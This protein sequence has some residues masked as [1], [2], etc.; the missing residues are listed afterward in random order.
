[1]N[2]HM[3]QDDEASAELRHLAAVPRQIISPANNSPIIGIF[4]DS[5]LGLYRF[6]RENIQFD[7]RQAMNLLMTHTNVNKSL[8]GN[9]K[10]LISNFELFSQILPPLSTKFNNG[11][12]DGDKDDKKTSNNVIEILNGKMLR[13]QLDKGVKKLI[14]SIFNDFGFNSSADFIDHLQGI[15]TEYMK[16]SAFSVGISDL[17]AD[18][19]TNDKITQ[20]ITKKKQQ[21]KDIIDQ[22]QI[23]VFE[24]NS[25]KSNE[26][27]FETQVN[28]ILNKAREEAGK[29][30]RNS[31]DKN[32]RFVVMVNAGS[33]GS[34][35][36]IAQMISCLGQQNVDG[37]RIGYGFEDRTLPHYNKFDD[38]PEARGFVE[39]SFIQGLSP[40]ELFF[41]AMGGRV[42][43][44]DTAVKSVTWETPIV[45]IENGEP[46]YSEIGRWID[47][48]LEN[49]KE[50]VRHFEERQMEYLNVNNN[51][52]IPTTDENGII[53]WGEITAVTRHDPGDELY[54]IK[55]Q[56]G[57]EVIVTESK[58]LLIW[59][60]DTK[61]FVETLTPDIIVGD[62]VPVTMDLCDS[63]TILNEINMEKYFPK[64]KYI[65]GNDLIIGLK[66]MNE[67][68]E[69]KHKIEN[70]WWDKN[71]NNIFTLPYNKKSS[72]QRFAVRSNITAI[73]EDYIY[74][75]HSK[76]E[77][78]G[79][80][81]KFELNY[82]NGV[83]IGL[84][85]AEGN[86]HSGSLTITNNNENIQL[87]VK[88]WFNKNNI[89]YSIV[90]KINNIGGKTYSIRGYSSMMCNFIDNF[91]GS[92]AS[93]KFIP[94]E[95]FISNKDFVKGLL[96]GYFSGD[97]HISRNSIEASSASKRLIEG[98][99]MLC[100]R[101]GIFC[102]VFM[103]Q[104]KKNNLNTQ[105]IKPSYR[106]SIRSQWGKLFSENILLID[107]FKQDKLNNIKWNLKH[108]N[109][110]VYN[111]VVLDKIIS[112]EIVDVKK[113][114]KV[115][116]LTIPS[117]LNFGL[118][119]GLQVRDTSETGYIQRRLIKGMEDLKV[120][121]DMTVRNNMGKIVQFEYGDDSMETTKVESQTLP[122]V[123][124]TVEDI[125]SHYTI[126]D[127]VTIEND[128]NTMTFTQDALK[129]MTSQKIDLKQKTMNYIEN[130][131][132]TRKELVENVF[133]MEHNKN[134]NCPVHF[135]RIINNV[136]HQ[137][138]IKSNSLVDVT[139]LECFNIIEECKET[140]QKI[141]SVK[142]NKLFEALFNYYMIPKE[143][144]YI[145]RY[146]RASLNYLTQVIITNYK[147]SIIAPGEMV[148]MIAAQSIGEPT[149]QLTL[150]S[151]TYETEIP[152]RDSR[153][154]MYNVQIGDFVNK[155]INECIGKK[156]YYA[157]KD[158][159]Y[160][161]L[162]KES[163]YYEI[164][165]PSEDGEMLWCRIE[166]VTKHPVVNEDG[167]NTML[168]ITTENEREVIVTKAKSLLKVID[169]KLLESP[170]S[171]AKIGDY[172][173]INT[174]KYQHT[175][176]Y[177]LDLKTVLSPKE[178]L[179]MS[180][181][182][183]AIR[184]KDEGHWWKK[185]NNVD[186]VLP[187]S[188][189]DAFLDMVERNILHT[190]K[191]NG[192][193]N[194]VH[195]E[196]G[197]VYMKHN[198][199]TASQ[200]PEL[201]QLDYDFGYLL[202]AY[203]AEGCVTK[204]QISIANINN[205]YLEPIKRFC[206]KFNITYKVYKTE[207]K[208]QERWT[209]QD[210]RI[211]SKLLT[212]LLVKLCNKISHTKTLSNTIVYSNDECK[213]GFL[214][215]YIGG[216]G[217]ISKKEKCII[218]FSTSK[219]L[220]EKVQCMLN[221]F[222][223]Y[224]FIRKIK[225]QT[226]NNRGTTDFQQAYRLYVSNNQC[227]KLSS[228]LDIKIDYKKE[229]CM[230]KSCQEMKL[231]IN[232]FNDAYI[233][234]FNSEKQEYEMLKRSDVNDAYK[235]IVFEKIKSIE[236]VS[237]TTDYAYD[238]T[239][240]TTRNFVTVNGLNLRDTFHSAGISSK[241]NVTRGV[242]R[243]QEILSLSKE[244]KNP[245]LSIYLKPEDQHNKLKAQQLM[246]VLEHTQ[247]R[248]VVESV[249]ICYD[250]DN[251]NTLIDEDKELISQYKMFE[252][253]T[254]ECAQI[255]PLDTQRS[256]WIIR[257]VL[258]KEA[259]LDKNITMDDVHFAL[260][261][262]YKDEIECIFSDF[263]SDK[264]VFR[265]RLM[266]LLK[267]KSIAGASKGLDQSDD[268]YMLKNVQESMLDNIILKGAKN[269]TKVILRK[270]QDNVVKEGLDYVKQ[271]AWVLDTIGTNLLDMLSFDEIDNTRT[272][273][274]DIIEVHNV[275]G[276]EATRQCIYNEIA[277]VLEFD[278]TYINYHHMAL[279]CDRM[280]YSKNLISIFRHG[281][282]NDN[283]GPIA[284]AT[285]EETPEMFLR[286]ARHAEFDNMRGV[287]ANI[288]C[289]QEGN[290]GT[291]SFQVVVDLMKMTALGN[292]TLQQVQN[293]DDMFD[294]IE[295][296]DD[297]CAI[298]NIQTIS[299]VNVIKSVNVGDDNDYEPDF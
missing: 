181:V 111:N 212:E 271:E 161:E 146:N 98:I 193:N 152:V 16:T 60:K 168:K 65:H 267:K 17:I 251:L 200:L 140:I 27:E 295:N 253:M 133:K 71:N 197:N 107:N 66:K 119:N 157:S 238:L 118:A 110:D 137:M 178:Y 54:K 281:I 74:P 173:P 290:F 174:M 53:T 99:S 239:V 167:T 83:F 277:D 103:T 236:E 36:N 136:K 265:V 120:E 4:Q 297:P 121:Y 250:P 191:K 204:T 166:A 139:P 78:V 130:M 45:F 286:A 144:L 180:E 274:N 69:G 3:P 22:L 187:Y 141:H 156:E 249:S 293:I 237:N 105:N 260:N 46:K 150:N 201:M 208:I 63:S 89:T 194:S 231:N 148:G 183:K 221:T 199:R 192:T 261:A 288:M 266:D 216:D 282:N 80:H 12:F 292:K 217:Y 214:D 10:K 9:Q 245:S 43:L 131:I 188:R 284:K 85:L 73:K 223:I 81:N 15:V 50:K 159:T 202:G 40:Q 51:I 143:L 207:N 39:N 164:L 126:P 61:K 232:K 128:L 276:I 262:G 280:C 145:H 18:E 129:R 7:S 59:N 102:K 287:S 135:Q 163:Q 14:H 147:K 64:N 19:E 294:G 44:I 186:F 142:V 41:H 32:N 222:E 115:Y 132:D 169:G 263:N 108:K 125:Y 48:Q 224:S 38:G 299:N 31:L 211:Y 11:I 171:D 20:A 272:F 278:G 258:D 109:F 8:F 30:G 87:F 235:N 269:I 127:D 56:G 151:V 6:T 230:K 195:Y 29:I 33:K 196:Y 34:D 165:A 248:D 26:E 21:V 76:R 154:Y 198:S 116:D 256:K 35:I 124:M 289:G 240:E 24:N 185:H 94:N 104:L 114:P 155:Y 298:S 255:S 25:G 77:D 184:Y 219:E 175:P 93:N 122:L 91:V 182:E 162:D 67:V 225:K 79:I 72:L 189:S 233:P 229:E 246:Y 226:S 138:N 206:E 275:L 5:L 55:T 96:N 170:G 82:E 257:F 68:M 279:L 283:I 254:E 252:S 84:Y 13:G 243:I 213:K 273:S 100:S 153:G 37:K 176:V 58:S 2:M 203:C 241:S 90:D 210:I 101:F 259:M 234:S 62:C 160:A 57:R 205:D 92:G 23:G 28:N 88:E 296:K 47:Q 134:V 75:Y 190:K 242:P 177:E 42:G 52:Y 215:A 228:L 86:T 179:F 97:G 123:D 172:V 106:I 291:S 270:L 49:N 244:A 268:V 70:G 117:T 247:L 158:T 227:K 112:I 1:M 209:S 149:T 95:A 264:L 220:L 285:F 218:M 113:Y